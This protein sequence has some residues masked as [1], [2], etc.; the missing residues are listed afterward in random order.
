MR[1]SIPPVAVSALRRP[2]AAPW[3]RAFRPVVDGFGLVPA[4]R[5]RGQGPTARHDPDVGC[6]HSVRRP[7]KPWEL[8]GIAGLRCVGGVAEPDEFLGRGLDLFL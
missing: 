1:V 7:P 3:P 2:W 5:P 8:T 6:S 4:P